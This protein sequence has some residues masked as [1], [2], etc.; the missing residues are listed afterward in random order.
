MHITPN[1]SWIYDLDSLA[2]PA[3]EKIDYTKYHGVSTLITSRGCP[4]SCSFCTVHA[5]VGKAFRAR[6]AESVLSEIRHQ[7]MNYG[8]REFHIED[9]NFTF[10]MDRVTDICRRVV[11]EGLDIDLYLPNGMT[12]V[13]LT[14][15]IACEMAAAGF[16]RLFFGLETTDTARLRK[17]KK[18]FTSA[19]KVE[20][21]AKW[22]MEH[23]V[24]ASASL[25]VGLPGQTI[26]EIAHDSI[27]MM[28][29]GVPFM[30]NPFYPIPGSQDFERCIELGL[31]ARET[32]A[33]LFDMFNFSIGSDVLSPDELYWAWISTQAIT[34]W[35]EFI[36]AGHLER[37]NG[38]KIDAFQ[39]I[40]SLFA[41]A[42]PQHTIPS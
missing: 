26:S 27:N 36:K 31:I 22:F 8:I 24:V 12:V 40:V 17:I 21:G 25:I 19:D 34:I 1:Q 32:E 15:E 2:M 3:F 42:R 41:T 39:A 16:K 33:A 7:V 4:F 30:T 5:T 38:G 11:D 35:P 9:D 37:G 14:R 18:G 10:D 23:G 28:T 20:A 6:T 29:R 13:S